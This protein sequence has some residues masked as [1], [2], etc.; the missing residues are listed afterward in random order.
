MKSHEIYTDWL[1]MYHIVKEKYSN[2]VKMCATVNICMNVLM[3]RTV[4]WRMPEECMR[5]VRIYQILIRDRPPILIY[6]PQAVGVT[7]R[8]R[9]QYIA[10]RRSDESRATESVVGAARRHRSSVNVSAF[11]TSAVF[12]A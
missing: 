10:E 1:L 11:Y 7:I 5:D 9:L 2:M 12:E 6:D 8:R 4:L 3:N